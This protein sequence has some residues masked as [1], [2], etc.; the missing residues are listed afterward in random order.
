VD[1]VGPL[2]VSA[3]GYQYL[4]TV[5]D[6]ST[7]WAEAFPLKAVAT[8]DCVDALVSGWVARFGVPALIT[9]DRGVQFASAFSLVG[10]SNEEAG[11]ET[12]D[13]YC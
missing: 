1:L 7:R 8:T 3:E 2:P 13:D 5:I 9:S 10:R 12:H 6:R 4:F 11:S